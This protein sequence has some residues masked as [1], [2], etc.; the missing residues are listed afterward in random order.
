METIYKYC[1]KYG[2]KVLDNLE[3][4]ITPPNQFNDPFEFTPK[5]ICSD[6]VRYATRTLERESTL[7]ILYGMCISDGKFSGSFEKF[8]Q[9]AKQQNSEWVKHLAEAPQHTL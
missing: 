8:K 3:L 1:G 5:M 4:K 7:Q 6:P 2:L 9:V